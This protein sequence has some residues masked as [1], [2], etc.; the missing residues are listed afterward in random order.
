[1]GVLGLRWLWQQ[2]QPQPCGSSSRAV[3]S[4]MQR[5]PAARSSFLFSFSSLRGQPRSARRARVRA[6]AGREASPHSQPSPC[7]A[8]GLATC[9][10]LQRGLFLITFFLK[11]SCFPVV[12]PCL[13]HAAAIRVLGAIS[14][15]VC[16]QH[17]S[18][19]QSV[20]KQS[21]PYSPRCWGERVAKAEAS[22]QVGLYGF[23][24]QR[25]HHF[26]F[27]IFL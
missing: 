4:A 23:L 22:T 16:L 26:F 18:R 27:N 24:R 11:E 1:M 21:W 17:V 15:E 12:L 9:S 13:V 14:Q 5:A 20:D 19:W 7:G 3:L 25:R 8:G 10:R 6:G 2:L